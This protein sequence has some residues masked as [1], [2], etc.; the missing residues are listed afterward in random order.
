MIDNELKVWA[1]GAFDGEGSALIEVTSKPPVSKSNCFQIV[2]AVVNTDMNLVTPFREA[3]GGT[4]ITK[5]ASRYTKDGGPRKE[6]YQLNFDPNGEAQTFLIDILPYLR[7]RKIAVV[8]VL[9][10]L[11]ARRSHDKARLQSY[12]LEGVDMGLWKMSK[13]YIFLGS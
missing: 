7:V 13:N 11:S 10:A 5:L 2:V 9:R 3:W 6:A 1:A 12:Y 8:L 4:L